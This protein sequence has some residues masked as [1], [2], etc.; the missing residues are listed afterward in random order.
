[1]LR[2]ATLRSLLVHKSLAPTEGPCLHDQ[3][4]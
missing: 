4:T 1:M 2:E 3:A